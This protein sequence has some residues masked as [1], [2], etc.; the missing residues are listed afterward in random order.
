MGLA[1]PPLLVATKG[2]NPLSLLPK[3]VEGLGPWCPKTVCPSFLPSGL[4]Q[5]FWIMILY[6]KCRKTVYYKPQFIN[7]EPKLT[8]FRL[9]VPY[10]NFLNKTVPP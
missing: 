2:S 7:F 5:W 1:L 6:K 3:Q 4:I 8:V 10:Q 9:G